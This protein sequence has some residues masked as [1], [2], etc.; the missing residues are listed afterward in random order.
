MP[1]EMSRRYGKWNL[2]TNTGYY[3]DGSAMVA[4]DL[5]VVEVTMDDFTTEIYAVSAGA[6]VGQEAPGVSLTV[7]TPG[8]PTTLHEEGVALMR[9][10]MA[11]LEEELQ[12]RKAHILELTKENEALNRVNS[13][14]LEKLFTVVDTALADLRS[15]RSTE[16]S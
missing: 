6:P 12:R 4:A 3:G 2:G 13:K 8:E 16:S 9:E 1:R 5:Q 7:P 14:L 15:A 11:S 10:R